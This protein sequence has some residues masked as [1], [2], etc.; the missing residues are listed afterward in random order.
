MLSHPKLEQLTKD[1]SNF[2]CISGW[3]SKLSSRKAKKPRVSR[4]CGRRISKMKRQYQ[5]RTLPLSHT[6]LEAETN[7][8]FGTERQC[9]GLCD[10]LLH[11]ILPPVSHHKDVSHACL[12]AARYK[13]PS[14]NDNVNNPCTQNIPQKY[15]H[16]AVY[17]GFNPTPPPLSLTQ[18]KFENNTLHWR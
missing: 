11:P 15:P 9:Q 14:V 1:A 6:C 12:Q 2:L 5:K 13:S 18:T 4:G 17:R 3:S 8:N 16:I 10:P 7:K